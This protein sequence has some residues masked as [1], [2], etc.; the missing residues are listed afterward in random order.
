MPIINNVITN[1]NYLPTGTGGVFL[2]LKGASI[3]NDGYVDIDDIHIGMRGSN[4][5]RNSLLC[6]TDA[7]GCCRVNGPL[8]VG[9]WFLPNGISLEP[10]V[11]RGGYRRNR[12]E[13]VT[14]LYRDLDTAGSAQRGRFRCEIPDEIMIDQIRYVNICKYTHAMYNSYS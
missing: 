10:F 8:P 13:G 7:P 12:N 11:S 9:D 1:N 4:E 5:D 3:V 14:R 2:S 6:H